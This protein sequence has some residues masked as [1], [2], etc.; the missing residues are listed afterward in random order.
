MT[1]AGLKENWYVGDKKG[2]IFS[3]SFASGSL[4]K[5]EAIFYLLC[6]LRSSLLEYANTL[7]YPVLSECNSI[8]KYSVRLKVLRMLWLGAFQQPSASRGS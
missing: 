4:Y 8:L 7:A 5:L 1:C 2:R 6:L 3:G